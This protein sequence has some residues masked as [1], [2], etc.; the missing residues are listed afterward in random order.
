MDVNEILGA[1]RRGKKARSYDD[2]L[3]ADD[4]SEMRAARARAAERKFARENDLEGED[5]SI[6][7]RLK[8]RIKKARVKKVLNKAARLAR[9]KALAAKRKAGKGKKKPAIAKKP[10]I[11]ALWARMTPA[12][13]KATIAAVIKKNP[14]LKK[15]LA[16]A[17]LKK[18]IEARKE[19]DFIAPSQTQSTP[20]PST[21]A[22]ESPAPEPSAAP[23]PT[24][25]TPSA[26]EVVQ[27]ETME[28]P[29][30]EAA[31]DE[32]AKDE[33]VDEAA[34]DTSEELAEEATEADSDEMAE[35]TAE[36]EADQDK[37][38]AEEATDAATESAGDLLLGFMRGTH[39]MCRRHRCFEQMAVAKAR[40]LAGQIEEA[41]GG[42]IKA[43][44]ILGAVKL[45]AKAKRGDKKAK[46]GIKAVT[47]LAKGKTKAAPKAKKAVA[48]LKIAHKIMKKTGTA[49]GTGKKKVALK[50]KIAKKVVA[51][52]RTKVPYTKPVQVLSSGLKSYSAYQ[53]GMATIPG[54]ARAYYGTR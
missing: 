18:R 41:C 44:H 11:K 35:P 26:A 8:K 49:K 50:K 1:L 45:I 33:A 13:R 6:L 52:K 29:L 32:E 19:G 9:L 5:D 40:P 30:E 12:R 38:A 17:L 21:E 47:K 51:R 27:E 39:R 3:T 22:S 20:V 23:F 48:K 36:E 16:V 10:V 31:A 54:Y 34:Q 25:E 4:V 15:K 14:K 53:R 43:E 7:G 2:S 46:K 37:E 42:A 28:A 24:Q